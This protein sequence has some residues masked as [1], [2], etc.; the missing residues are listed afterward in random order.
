MDKST[1][2]LSII[3]AIL[4]NSV[5]FKIIMIILINRFSIGCT[6]KLVLKNFQRK[7]LIFRIKQVITH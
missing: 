4:I 1:I 3:T 7:L 5:E 2:D 6:F